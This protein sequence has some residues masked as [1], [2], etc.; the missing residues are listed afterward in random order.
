MEELIELLSFLKAR[1]F[2]DL[3]MVCSVE[4]LIEAAKHACNAQLIFRVSIKGGRVKDDWAIRAFSN[5]APPQIAV[6]KR[7][8][9][10][11]IIKQLGNLQLY[12]K[13]WTKETT[14]HVNQFELAAMD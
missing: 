5:V 12:R 14:K 13:N 1:C 9:N 10:R 8:D 6:Q 11:H 3:A 4:R 7:W 2:W